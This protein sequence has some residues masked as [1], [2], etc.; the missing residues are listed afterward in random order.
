[1]LNNV[2]N[3]NNVIE[4]IVRLSLCIIIVLDNIGSA[5]K[6]LVMVVQQLI[7][8]FSQVIVV[9]LQQLSIQLSISKSHAN[10]PVHGRGWGLGPVPAQRNEVRHVRIVTEFPHVLEQGGN[11]NN[12]NT[13][14]VFFMTNSMLTV[15]SESSL[16]TH[17]LTSA[18]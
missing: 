1:M 18:D 2:N 8:N 14:A 13:P 15:T 11:N 16:V 3:V 5:S 6:G 7:Q 4:V 12:N 17:L 9:F 10:E